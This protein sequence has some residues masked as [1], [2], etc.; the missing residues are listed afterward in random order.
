MPDYNAIVG[1]DAC[2]QRHLIG[3]NRLKSGWNWAASK[4]NSR[5]KE[6]AEKMLK[7]Y[8]HVQGTCQNNV[9]LDAPKKTER[10]TECQVERLMSKYMES[11]GIK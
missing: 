8:G 10:M 2:N 5:D 6:I 1:L 3:L 7:W 9:R 11:V 4:S